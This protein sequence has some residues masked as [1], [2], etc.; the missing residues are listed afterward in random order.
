MRQDDRLDADHSGD[1]FDRWGR[2]GD[3]RQYARQGIHD[4]EGH[5]RSSALSVDAQQRCT[6]R[7][8]G[9]AS[10]TSTSTV[11]LASPLR[12]A[13]LAVGTSQGALAMR[14]GVNPSSHLAERRQIFCSPIARS[15]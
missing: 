15:V 10:S 6:P 7:R 2:A 12:A 13:R 5:V 8:Q 1:L 11:A 4:Q 14:A 3:R 9:G